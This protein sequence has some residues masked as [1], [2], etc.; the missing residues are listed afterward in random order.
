[1]SNL[2]FVLVNFRLLM[3]DETLKQPNFVLRSEMIGDNRV[4]S[5][6]AVICLQFYA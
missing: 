4:P 1:M 2:K 3:I 5:H 6:K